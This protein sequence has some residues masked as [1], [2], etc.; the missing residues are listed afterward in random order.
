MIETHDATSSALWA[1]GQTM[2][3]GGKIVFLNLPGGVV[4]SCIV[5]GSSWIGSSCVSNG[6]LLNVYILCLLCLRF[7]KFHFRDFVLFTSS[8]ITFHFCTLLFSGKSSPLSHSLEAA[9]PSLPQSGSPHLLF[10]LLCDI[11]TTPPSLPP[12][13]RSLLPLYHIPT[14]QWSYAWESQITFHDPQLI[15]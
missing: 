4:P 14:F 8:Y 11:N 10:H 7:L 1:S 12:S 2:G 5:L 9:F 3:D 15:N 13:R 6:C